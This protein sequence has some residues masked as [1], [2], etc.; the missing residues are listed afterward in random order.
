M[1]LC[2]ATAAG[3]GVAQKDETA[4]RLRAARRRVVAA[5]TFIV[6]I[7][8]LKGRND[9]AILF[10]FFFALSRTTATTTT[11]VIY[12]YYQRAGGR[13]F[14]LLLLLLFGLWR[15]KIRK[16]VCKSS[17]S[18]KYRRSSPFP[19]VAAAIQVFCHQQETRE[20]DVC[21]RAAGWEWG[22]RR[23]RVVPYLLN[24]RFHFIFTKKMRAVDDFFFFCISMR[25]T[26][27][28]TNCKSNSTPPTISLCLSRAR[29]ESRSFPLLGTRTACRWIFNEFHFSPLCS[30][31]QAP[32]PVKA[33]CGGRLNLASY[34]IRLQLQ[35]KRRNAAAAMIHS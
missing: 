7:I 17:S 22:D 15:Y 28:D 8:Y 5:F 24:R 25:S 14:I 27:E 30:S 33:G 9:A 31:L 10:F 29:V 20:D 13:T 2:N 19:A 6:I 1:E 35:K 32:T 16:R 12:D 21:W 23:R 4:S 11:P 3:P 18:C 34:N 26:A